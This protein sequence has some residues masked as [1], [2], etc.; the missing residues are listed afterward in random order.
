[1]H[2]P[3]LNQILTLNQAKREISNSKRLPRGSPHNP[4]SSTRSSQAKE[5]KMHGKKSPKILLFFFSLLLLL[6]SPSQSLNLFDFLL[7]SL[8][9]GRHTD[10]REGEGSKP[11][12]HV[13]TL[14]DIA[15]QSSAEAEL[16]AA[17]AAANQA[18]WHR[19]VLSDLNLKQ[20]GCTELFVDNQASIAISNNPVFYGNTKHFLV[21][22]FV[23]KDLQKE[24]PVKL[25][26]AKLIFNLQT[27]L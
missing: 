4:H 15:A 9:L 27:F 1:M 8:Y 24:G 19:K 2:K 7:L 12:Q 6:S 17:N 10:K 16:I 14:K 3:K 11:N 21:K 5:M 22:M 25:S 13:T 26:T 18:L 23:V 20:D